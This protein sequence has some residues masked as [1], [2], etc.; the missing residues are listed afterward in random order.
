MRV[1]P[2]S[3]RVRSTLTDLPAAWRGRTALLMSDLHLGNIN[4]VRFARRIAAM[5]QRLEPDVIFIPGDLFDGTKADPDRL[6]APLLR[7]ASALRRFLRLGQP[8]GV[9][10]FHHYAE[11]LRHSR[12]FGCSTTSASLVDGLQIVGVPYSDSNYPV[13]LRHFL[14]NLQ[15][16]D[17]PASI[18]LQHVPTPLAHRGAGRREPAAERP[19]PRRPDL[20]LLLGSPAAHSANSPTDCSASE[21][22]RSTPRAARAPGVRPCASEHIPKIV[23]LTFE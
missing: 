3:P 15:L 20:S 10:R 4:G 8:R 12:A 11:A 7:T 19:H 2:C 13:R 18:L 16:N 1:D 5:A 9:R 22:C 23:L 14:M 21:S 6:A 17:G